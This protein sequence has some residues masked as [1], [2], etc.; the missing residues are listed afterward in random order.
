MAIDV[1]WA[2]TA[3]NP[4][5]IFI[6]RADLT[7]VQASPEIRE[8]DV[9]VFRKDLRTIE[10]TVAGAPWPETHRHQTEAALSGTTFARIVE[11]LAPYQVEFEDGQYSVRAV[12]ANHNILDVKVNNQVSL[13]VFLSSGLINSPDILF[14]S[15]N[16]GVLV[17]PNNT[18]GLAA[19]GTTHPSGTR[20]RP[21]N[22]FADALTIASEFGLSTLY[23]LGQGITLDGGLDFRGLRI[24]GSSPNAASVSVSAAAQVEGCEFAGLTLD[25]VFD[26]L[27]LIERCELG[28]ASMVEGLI[29]GCGLSGTITLSAGT[30]LTILDCYDNI[31]GVGTPVIDFGGVGMPVILR[32]YQGAM[33]MRNKSGSD[34]VSVDLTPGRLVL[35]STVTGGAFLVKG[36]GSPTDDQSTGTAALDERALVYGDSL[37]QVARR[38]AVVSGVDVVVDEAAETITIGGVVIQ[39]TKVGDMVTYSR[40]S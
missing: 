38:M 9:D 2:G 21:V 11:I 15:F 19:A 6:P 4:Y 31:A 27:V 23:I 29:S 26:G 12:G 14:A 17:D 13:A 20:R 33:T 1:D 40:V 25:G 3:T 8:L 32:N 30:K 35:E 7:L 10:A 28:N 22:N 24:E 16:G 18:T 39:R 5:R 37:E 34:E 36:I